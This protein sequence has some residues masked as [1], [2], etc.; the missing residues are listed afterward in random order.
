[1]FTIWM[2]RIKDTII[3][4]LW[5][6]QWKNITF[7]R[8]IF[9]FFASETFGQFQASLVEQTVEKYYTVRKPIFRIKV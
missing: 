9:R 8:P 3:N 1:M 6:R 2:L 5:N 7:R 4:N